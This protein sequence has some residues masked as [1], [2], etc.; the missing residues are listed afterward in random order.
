MIFD[1]SSD[2]YTFKELPK[3]ISGK[4][5]RAEI[6]A[7]DWAEDGEETKSEIPEVEKEEAKVNVD[8]K[9]N[10]ENIPETAKETE[11]KKED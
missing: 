10:E 4:V 6:K 11:E 2:A 1:S 3:T 8:V 7:Q 5:R 9:E